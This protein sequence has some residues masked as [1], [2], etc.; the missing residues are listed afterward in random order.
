MPWIGESG[1]ESPLGAAAF[2]GVHVVD[3]A[4]EC[5]CFPEFLFQEDL[6]SRTRRLG[7]AVSGCWARHFA[8]T[9]WAFMEFSF[10]GRYA[11]AR[12]RN[13]RSE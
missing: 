7:R 2:A 5:A 12:V 1:I 6:N 8:L 11:N 4:R 3:A 9:A 13:S 10:V